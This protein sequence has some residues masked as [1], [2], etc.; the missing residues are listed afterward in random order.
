MDFPFVRRYI[1]SVDSGLVMDLT[2]MVM[3]HKRTGKFG[4]TFT[5]AHPLSFGMNIEPGY[6]SD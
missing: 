1:V 4:H 3:I 2:N 5:C 6:Y